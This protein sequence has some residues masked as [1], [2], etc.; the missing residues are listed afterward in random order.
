MRTAT[1]LHLSR[2]IAVVVAVVLAQGCADDG[3]SSDDV[4]GEDFV[5]D[6]PNAPG[7]GGGGDPGSGE[8]TGGSGTDGAGTGGDDGGE[9]PDGDDGGREIAE[10]DIIQLNGDRL[11]ALSEY[12][13]LAVI[14]VSQPQTKLPVL[15]RWRAQAIPFEMYLDGAQAFVMFNDYG[16]YDYDA[17]VG[18]WVYRSSSNLV[19]LDASNPADI[20]VR[21][22]FALPGSIQDSRRVGDVLYV[23]TY[24]DGYCWNCKD[25]PNTTITSL[26]VADPTRPVQ[27]DQI[28]FENPQQDPWSWWGARSVSATDQRMYVGGPV[29]TDWDAG[30]S[31]IDVIDISDPSGVMR[32]GATLQV[33]GEITNRWQMDEHAG[34]LRVLSQPPGWSLDQPPVVQTFAVDSADALTPLGRLVMTLPR[35]EQLQ[36][37][38]FDGPRGYAITFERTDPLFTLDL[39]NPANPVQVGEL[40]IPGFV[41]HMEPRGERILALGFDRGNPE[42]SV[43]VS[44]FDVSDFAN[45]TMLSRINF[46]GDWA[47]FGEDQNRVHKAF[48]ILDELGLLLVPFQGWEYDETDYC[49]GTFHS[50]VQL[51]DFTADSLTERGQ[52]D[53][54]GRSRRAFVH[55]DTLLAVS[56]RSVES[57]DITDRDAPAPLQD[58]ALAAH[59]DRTAIDATTDR[60]VRLARDWYTDEAI[61]EVVARDQA[62]ATSP[63]GRLVLPRLAQGESNVPEYEC[64][65]EDWYGAGL[66]ARDGYAYVARQRYDWT[67]VDGY[68]EPRTKTTLEVFDLRDPAAMA[69]TGELELPDYRG[70]YGW[71]WG[72]EYGGGV[73]HEEATSVMIDDAIVMASGSTIYGE[74]G[75]LP[76]S[77]AAF[78][79]VDLSTPG[80]PR[81]AATIERPAALSHGRI[82][83]FGDELVS[84]SVRAANESGSQVRYFL[85]RLDMSDVSRPTLRAPVNVP[86]MPVAYDGDAGRAITVDFKTTVSSLPQGRE[87]ECWGSRYGAWYDWSNERCVET[88]RSLKLVRVGDSGAALLDTLDLEDGAQGIA[89]VFGSSTRL[90]AQMQQPYSYGDG[91]T[92]DGS[93]GGGGY[94]PP[95]LDLAIVTGLQGDELQ[96]ASRVSV[97]DSYGWGSRVSGERLI[98]AESNGLGVV[99]ATNASDPE[100]TVHELYSYGCSD[101][102]IDGAEI[103]C[104]LGAYGLQIVDLD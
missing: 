42:G 87:E 29:W 43:N 75:Q 64:W 49:Y 60:V 47:D 82:Q 12:G 16:S 23:V 91:V 98:Y 57:F 73:G 94:T 55:Q 84:W 99:D 58:A 28:S 71:G 44:L 76:V 93:E 9:P 27:V 26:N 31:Q 45:P 69:K 86:G 68:Y 5:S 36:S 39:S 61:L 81:L 96:L 48:N 89:A 18:D 24:E 37:V 46:G 104:A 70:Y 4:A 19:A 22:E 25:T 3:G 33:E 92:P 20:A 54:R 74:N 6:N 78:T 11:F 21:G 40:E 80:Q 59:V 17:A 97:S 14:D 1:L 53:S 51:I 63:L 35:P 34:V 95:S 8:S 102:T 50:A 88:E 72:W 62:E 66:F 13:G 67:E 65:Y 38:R 103:L 7:S 15:G 41:Y 101:M 52:A 32:R 77:T 2:D 85:E 30:Y 79:V 83:R 56:D 100:I 90:F 10:A